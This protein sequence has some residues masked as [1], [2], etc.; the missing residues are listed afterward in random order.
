MGRAHTSAFSLPHTLV[1]GL[2]LLSGILFWTILGFPF[3][4]H[5]ESYIWAVHLH[6]GT[7]LDCVLHKMVTV[8]NHRPFGQAT[9]WVTFVLSGDSVVPAQIFNVA[10]ALAAWAL[11]LRVV[12]QRRVFAVAG[13]AVGGTLFSGY[14]YLFHLHGVFYSPVLLLL[15]VLV[16]LFEYGEARRSIL[17]ATLAALAAAMFHPYALLLFIAAAAGAGIRGWTVLPRRTL[18]GLAA[19]TLAAVVAII[20]LVLLPGDAIPATM[21]QRWA[22]FLTSYRATEIHPLVSGVAAVLALLTAASTPG[23]SRRRMLFLVLTGV[24]VAVLALAGLPLLFAWI[25]AGIAKMVLLRRWSLAAMIAVATLLPA[26]APTGS[27]TYSIY[28][29]MLL[30]VAV[31]YEWE[32][33]EQK[34]AH[35]WPGAVAVSCSVAIVLA[36]VL[37]AGVEVPLL[38]R[39]TTPILAERERTEQLVTIIDWWKSSPYAGQPIGLAQEAVNPVDMK[40]V[41]ERRFRPPTSKSYLARYLTYRFGK[42]AGGDYREPRL[43]ILF[44]GAPLDD[45]TMVYETQGMS[46]GP[47]RVVFM[48]HPSSKH[49]GTTIAP[50]LRVPAQ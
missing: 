15:V 41:G 30:A 36:I 1:Y 17:L 13:M 9:A 29:C 18:L 34:F 47:A 4:H 49:P 45:S 28:V 21:H 16:A 43:L 14:I 35:L 48:A 6:Q 46:A 31:S 19:A 22:G 39:F 11:M 25:G 24:A 26:I 8:A 33:M 42:N 23:E 20:V 12:K 5:N 10:V 40:D 27:P 2:L 7:F 37:R 50:S 38:S 3:Q 32:T 44:G